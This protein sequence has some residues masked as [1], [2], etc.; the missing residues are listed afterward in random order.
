MTCHDKP[1]PVPKMTAT[2]ITFLLKWEIHIF[3]MVIYDIIQE[4]P[5]FILV[6]KFILNRFD[7]YLISTLQ[8]LTS[9][10]W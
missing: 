6:I 4:S 7:N 9:K 8:P 10:S 5:L 3:I 2:P 1:I